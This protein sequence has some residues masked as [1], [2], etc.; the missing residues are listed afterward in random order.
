MS[1]ENCKIQDDNQVCMDSPKR[2]RDLEYKTKTIYR[3][4]TNYNNKTPWFNHAILRKD[5]ENNNP[6]KS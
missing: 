3:I 5:L 1:Q 6:N 2:N 4:K